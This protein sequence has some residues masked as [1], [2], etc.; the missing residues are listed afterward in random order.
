MPQ[1]CLSG[2]G[3]YPFLAGQRFRRYA[4]RFANLTL[5]GAQLRGQFIGGDQ[6]SICEVNQFQRSIPLFS[7]SIERPGTPD[8]TEVDHGVEAV[9]VELNF[10]GN[11]IGGFIGALGCQFKCGNGVRIG[12]DDPVLAHTALS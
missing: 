2:I 8:Q 3:R 1:G 9:G 12:I 7:V 10:I 6:L 11:G 5:G 4:E